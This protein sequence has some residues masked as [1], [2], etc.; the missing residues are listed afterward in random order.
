MTVVATAVTHIG[1]MVY[2]D[3][4]TFDD[5]SKELDIK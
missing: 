2:L 4:M 5:S 3:F 1:K